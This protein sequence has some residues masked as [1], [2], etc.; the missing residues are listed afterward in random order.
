VEGLKTELKTSRATIG[1]LS[2]QVRGLKS[3]TRVHLP[4][5]V[6]GALVGVGLVKLLGLLKARR[7]NKAAVTESEAEEEAED[8]A[9]EDK[10]LEAAQ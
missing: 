10:E 6:I 9:A 3:I 7:S 8:Q 2:K 1:R 4:S 5:L